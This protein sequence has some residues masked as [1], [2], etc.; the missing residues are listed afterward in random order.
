MQARDIEKATGTL[1]AS[2]RTKAPRRIKTPSFFDPF[3]P[4]FL[5]SRDFLAD[6]VKDHEASADGMGK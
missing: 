6:Q 2:K 5:P 3:F 4:P 1:M